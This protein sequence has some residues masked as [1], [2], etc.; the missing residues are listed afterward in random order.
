MLPGL[1]LLTALGFAALALM[2]IL[3]ARRDAWDRAAEAAANLNH[4]LRQEVGRSIEALDLRLRGMAE[5]LRDPVLATLPPEQRRL[6]LV[7]RNDLPDH[8]L[9]VGALDATGRMVLESTNAEPRAGDFAS[10]DYFAAHRD[11]PGLGLVVSRPFLG[12]RTGRWM[13]AASR[14]L[15][16]G[17]GRF[18]GV[19]AGYVDLSSLRS[20]FEQMA[21]G[22][23]GS[24]TLFRDD[25]ITLMRTPFAE[26]SIGADLSRGQ[27][28]R[29]SIATD[30]GQFL[31]RAALDGVQR[32]YTHS[33]IAGTRLVINVA[34]AVEDIEAGWRQRAWL[35]GI[36]TLALLAVTAVLAQLRRQEWRRRVV[37]ELAARESAANFRLLAE[38]SS[39]MVAR[40]DTQGIRR[41]ASP[42]ARRILGRAPEELVGRPALQDILPEDRLPV[43]A[44]VARLRRG[45]AEELTLCYRIRRPDG[46]LAWIESTVRVVVDATGKRDGVVAVSRDIS[47][48]KALE[49][50]LA[51]LAT[52]DGLT[53]LL[54]RR[55]FDAALE[56]A[57]RRCSQANEPLSVLLVDVDHFKQVNDTQGHAAGDACLRAVAALLAGTVR[58]AGDLVARYGGE[59]FVVL[60]PGTG[61]AAAERVAERMRAE[62]AAGI[63]P[64]S[65]TISIGAATM[66]PAS[67]CPPPH[68][69]LEAADAALYAAKR[70]GRNRVVWQAVSGVQAS[71]A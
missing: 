12:S 55:A 33:R 57:W 4:A 41:Y 62:V 8:V 16:D 19:V 67:I 50:Q 64:T 2:T 35:V 66:V 43:L 42:A 29:R 13:I 61:A 23:Q 36:A 56:V 68:R 39:D 38:H 44:E 59:E 1:G 20:L 37:A 48:R 26:G 25:G 11:Q 7:G 51:K 15:E 17:E 32:F 5:G 31:G 63:G 58:R 6:A 34:L 65:V 22:R 14:R 10:R 46:V 3:D 69:L 53:G 60:L 45:E 30:H 49:A 40:I 71:A 24:I 27:A 21:L 9:M 52:Q 47:E 70:G 18:A 54:N 28:F